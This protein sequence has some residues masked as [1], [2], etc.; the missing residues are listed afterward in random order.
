MWRVIFY[1]GIIEATAVGCARTYLGEGHTSSVIFCGVFGFA[2]L[3]AAL[4]E[5]RKIV[6]K[7][8]TEHLAAKPLSA[9]ASLL[10]LVCGLVAALLQAPT[11]FQARSIGALK[12]TYFVS[13]A[14]MMM[15]TAHF[16]RS[17][18]RTRTS[19]GVRPIPLR[20]RDADRSIRRSTEPV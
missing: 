20:E 19:A 6:V 11:F 18:W 10:G 5:L 1:T 3:V 14:V 15:M 12:F 13:V 2:V 7:G 9:N 4:W 16:A 8:P 17:Y